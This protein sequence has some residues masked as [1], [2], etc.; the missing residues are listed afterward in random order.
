MREMDSEIEKV[1]C[2]RRVVIGRCCVWKIPLSSWKQIGRFWVCGSIDHH[3]NIV[4]TQMTPIAKC[5]NEPATTLFSSKRAVFREQ[6]IA[7][8]SMRCRFSAASLGT[9]KVQNWKGPE[10]SNFNSVALTDSR[11]PKR[12]PYRHGL[13]MDLLKPLVL[14]NISLLILKDLLLGEQFQ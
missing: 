1:C 9:S 14:N 2:R 11:A 6:W 8:A 3:S 7:L 13:Y 4:V 12:V 5:S 10:R